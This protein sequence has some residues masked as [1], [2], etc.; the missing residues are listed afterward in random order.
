MLEQ[1]EMLEMSNYTNFR[2]YKNI[3]ECLYQCTVNRI[4]IILLS[5]IVVVLNQSLDLY[6][7]AV[8]SKSDYNDNTET[9]DH[10]WT[11]P[12]SASTKVTAVS[13]RLWSTM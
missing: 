4:F 1:Q 7:G 11:T 8:N 10:H 5:S 2:L 9:L 13:T 12:I 6:N 3:F